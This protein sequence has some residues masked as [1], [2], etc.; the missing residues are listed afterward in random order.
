MLNPTCDS[1][2][3]LWGVREVPIETELVH[4]REDVKS[5]VEPRSEQLC[6]YASFPSPL[7]SCLIISKTVIKSSHY[8]CIVLYIFQTCSDHF[9][10]EIL[11][12]ACI[13]ISSVED[14]KPC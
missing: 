10:A 14:S 11:Y 4:E 2:C 7:N 9:R 12:P 13:L 3:E 5:N 6:V 1:S 8:I